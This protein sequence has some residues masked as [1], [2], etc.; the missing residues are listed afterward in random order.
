VL[1]AADGLYVLGDFNGKAFKPETKKQRLWHGNFY[2]AQTFS[3]TPD[4]RRIQ[5][6]WARG[7]DFPGMP[8]N[9]Q[10]TTPVELT[11]RTT[12]DGVR[13]F[14]NP[15]KELEAIGTKEYGEKDLLAKPVD[16][17]IADKC[18]L[19]DVRAEIAVP[20]WGGFAF[21]LRGLKVTY[22]ATKGEVRCAGQVIPLKPE[23]GKVRLHLL[24]DRGSLEL[25]GNSGRVAAS[26]SARPTTRSLVFTPTS[27][28]KIVSL[29][30]RKLRSVWSKR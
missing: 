10:M 11:L 27:P 9:Q 12:P 8:F 22:D 15:V 30:V 14:A 3:D 2:A 19:L 21:N 16:Y 29:E 4:G 7:I 20:D 18:D 24:L 26:V 23:E 1:Y 13:M 28:V 25:F 17:V 6:G 5:I